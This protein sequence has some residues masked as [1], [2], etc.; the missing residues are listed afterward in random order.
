MD[1]VTFGEGL[2]RMSPLTGGPAPHAA[3]LAGY[4]GGAELNTAVAAARLGI[5]AGWISRLPD[6]APG[7]FIEGV[8][9]VHGVDARIEWTAKGR[10]GLYY[11][12]PGAAPRQS[13][14][15]YDR[16]GSSF[17][18]IAPGMMDWASL[19]RGARWFH[20]TGIT[21]ALSDSAAAVA[22]EALQ[23]AR[24]AGLTVSYDVN[25]RVKLWNAFRARA[26]QEPLMRF[27][28]L[29]VVSEEDARTVFD[30]PGSSAEELARSLAKRYELRT[31]AVTVRDSADGLGAVV[32][33][34]GV[35]HIAPRH[36][37]EVVERVGTGDAFTAGL[38]VS[39]LENRGWEDALRF[40]TAVAAC[41]LTMPGDFF[42]GRRADV[43]K[44]IDRVPADPSRSLH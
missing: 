21:P 36:D 8:A 35:T 31:V 14:V 40:A 38:I 16:A 7:R 26:V 6:T 25:F 30:A 39:R 20:V 37:V 34:N 11:L 18:E 3:N 19:L 42:V 1:L 10:T 32:V 17:S 29:L 44:L 22:L 28:D 23:A 33:A 2:I 24:D 27:V 15:V 43:E 4:V 13:S 12:A 41:K 9:R 5:A